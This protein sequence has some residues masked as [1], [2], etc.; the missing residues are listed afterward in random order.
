MP[1]LR[2]AFELHGGY[3]VDYEGDAFVV[4]FSRAENAAAARIL[5]ASRAARASRGIVLDRI[6]EAAYGP[7]SE[8]LQQFAG[9]GTF[10]R[11]LAAGA[12]LT[13]D[14]AAELAFDLA[15][16]YGTGEDPT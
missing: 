8:E 15:H 11:E 16:R 4:A 13:L 7:W 1:P 6:D 2:E 10:E 14:E 5:G 3:E 9:D 12:G